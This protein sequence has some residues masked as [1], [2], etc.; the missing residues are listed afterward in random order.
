VVWGLDAAQVAD[1][2]RRAGEDLPEDGAEP[3]YEV[4]RRRI[5]QQLAERMKS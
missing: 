4:W 2:A 3:A 5:Q 1:L